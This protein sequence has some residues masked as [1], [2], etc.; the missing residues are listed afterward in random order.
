MYV[1]EA[2]QRYSQEEI[3]N[4]SSLFEENVL[5]RTKEHCKFLRTALVGVIGEVLIM[6]NVPIERRAVLRMSTDLAKYVDNCR[7]LKL[8]SRR[9]NLAET[10]T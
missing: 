10:S 8:N 6:S 5:C 3:M 1:K 7:R 2:L 9:T 4:M